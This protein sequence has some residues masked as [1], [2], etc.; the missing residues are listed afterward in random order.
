MLI[1]LHVLWCGKTET[2]GVG[3]KIRI[4]NLY[5]LSCTSR[6]YCFSWIFNVDE[7]VNWS[8]TKHLR[9]VR[10][11]CNSF[12]KS[13]KCVESITDEI[14]KM[15]CVGGTKHCL[16]IDSSVNRFDW[17]MI[18]LVYVPSSSFN[19]ELLL[20]RSMAEVEHSLTFSRFDI[21]IS[22]YIAVMN[23]QYSSKTF[24]YGRCFV[25]IIKVILPNFLTITMGIFYGSTTILL[26]YTVY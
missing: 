8:A 25:Q 11:E 21:P 14:L 20:L 24:K 19:G 4:P 6:V 16:I 13:Y 18:K 7:C 9:R 17:K 15:F 2:V 1:G 10:T 3:M 26:W 23:Q 5:S 12:I 22:T